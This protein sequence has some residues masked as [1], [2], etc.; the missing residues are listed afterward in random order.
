MSGIYN[1]LLEQIR[2]RIGILSQLANVDGDLDMRELAFIYNICIRNSIELDSIADLISNPDPHISL[3]GLTRQQQESYLVDV[4][5]LMMIDGKV[6]P[7]EVNF[8]LGIGERLG[9]R[10]MDLQAFINEL[11]FETGVTDDYIRQR[12]GELP[13]L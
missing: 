9:F 5:S 3:D 4:L 2:C 11:M 13:R 8:A 10:P 12:V 1:K 6:L 7:A